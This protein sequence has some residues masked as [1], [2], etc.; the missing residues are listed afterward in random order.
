MTLVEARERAD[1]FGK[2][3]EP[4]CE[5][6]ELTGCLRRGLV[7]G[8]NTLGLDYICIPRFAEMTETALEIRLH[9]ASYWGT[10]RQLITRTF[11]DT[12][13]PEATASEPRN[14]L[15]EAIE[16]FVRFS[17]ESLHPVK[18]PF[19]F[20]SHYRL[21]TRWGGVRIWCCTAANMGAWWLWKTGSK[22]HNALIAER[23]RRRGGHFDPP[24]GLLL[25]RNL[26]GKTEA[27]IYAALEMPWL[28]PELRQMPDLDLS[29]FFT[30]QRR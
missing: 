22:A 16:G 3:L 23:A 11:I 10:E 27:E 6:V 21:L 17:D 20:G 30:L 15:L 7:M 5:R 14:L 18:R 29:D 13:N 4:F 26:Y 28:P 12:M 19:Q 1:Q 9:Q 25:G 24:H 8:D 2:R